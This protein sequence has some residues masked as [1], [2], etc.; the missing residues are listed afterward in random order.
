MGGTCFDREGEIV[1]LCFVLN[2]DEQPVGAFGM[3][4][5]DYFRALHPAL[6]DEGGVELEWDPDSPE[7]PG[8]HS[9]RS[10]FWGLVQIT[11]GGRRQRAAGLELMLQ[12][13]LTTGAKRTV[14]LAR[15]AVAPPPELAPKLPARPNGAG[16]AVAI[17]MA[18][19]NPPLELFQRQVDSIRS[20]T[21]RNWVC[22]I[23]DDCSRPD[24]YEE[25]V[26]VVEGDARFVLE[27]S[28]RRQGFYAN[29]ERALYLVPAEAGYVTL[30]DQDDF[31][32]PDKL[33]TLLDKLGDA[34]LIYSDARI[35]SRAGEEIAPTFWGRRRRNHDDLLS[36]LVANCVTGAASLFRRE[37]LDSA[38]PF[39]PAQFAHY[40]DHWIALVA[41]ALGRIDFVDRPLYD[42]VQH[43]ESA[44]GHTAATRIFTLRQ[45]AAN[46][47]A[48]PHERVRFYRE[49]YF[50]DIARLVAFATIL[51]LRCGSRASAAD[52][53]TLERFLA[54]EQ[55]WPAIAQLGARAVRELSGTPETLGAEWSLFRAIVWRRMLSASVGRRPGQRLRMDALPPRDL[56]PPG[57]RRMLGDEASRF[58][59]EKIRP[60][61]LAVAQSAPRRVNILIPTIDLEHLF[62]GYIAKLNLA[63]AL[64]QRGARVRLVT[65]DPVGQLPGDWNRTVESYSGLTGL[66]DQVE[67]SFGREAGRLEVNPGDSFI[68]STW[69]TA[70]VAQAA[71]QALGHNGF[72]YLIQEFEPMTFPWGTL[73]ALA[74]QSYRFRHFALFSS[75]LLREYFR[76]HEIGV[77]GQGGGP[78]DAASAS[79]QN[80]LTE[81]NAPTSAELGA[82]RRRRLLFYARPESHAARNTFELGILALGR[83]LEDGAFRR[84][85][86]LRGIGAVGGPR[87]I[88]LG[89][90]AELELMPR[91][92]QR[93]Y[94]SL[95]VEHD[96]GLALMYSPHPSLVPIEMASAGLLT[97][98]N[99]FENKTSEALAEISGNLIGGDPTVDGIAG[100]LLEAASGVEDFE[101]RSRGASV[102]W[103]QDWKDSFDDALLDRLAEY[104]A[105]PVRAA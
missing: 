46:L 54:L 75:E 48:D 42:Y 21:H 92:A 56:S 38:L 86:E 65:V 72:V 26:G 17:C 19:Y 44:L 81:V 103:S 4:R 47:F 39:P 25:I 67:V 95:L 90:D 62:G 58:V 13:T 88:D 22:L 55:S 57:V 34:Q 32:Y 64:A 59:A 87:Q 85:W 102:R 53:R 77:Y 40:H 71:C 101:R 29:F 9:Y 28:E 70:H 41:R 15:I 14:L 61:E 60:L 100:A 36:L 10:G 16:P 45:R 73:S 78:A 93:D 7:D 43:G 27:R 76:R 63:H 1:S 79:F 11:G 23:S 33:E 74:S 37:L 94:A 3:P 35:V 31:W 50:R 91:V 49:R 20:Q 52:R 2:G 83:A 12:A 89:G 84:D 96:V 105:F 68:A 8:M 99:T 66:F 69:W 24:R 80:A 18:T 98:T 51:C 82:R 30:A 5:L 97:V 6:Q 104:L